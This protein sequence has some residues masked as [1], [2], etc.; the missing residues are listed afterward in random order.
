[1]SSRVITVQESYAQDLAIFRTKFHWGVLFAF[2]LFLLTC[3]LFFSDR[4][5]TIMTM[6]GIAVISVHGLNILT[7][8]CGQ[9]SIGHAGFMAVGGYASAILCAKL[10]FPFWVALPCGALTAGIAGLIFG[11]P[12]LKIKGF[13][14]IMA[15]IA[16]QFI[17]IWTIIQ[18]RSITG[19]ADG[20]SVP[21]PTIGSIALSSKINY[22]Y[23]VM[24]FACLATILAKNIMR[25]RAGRA[26]IAIRDND[27]AAEV[28]GIS[29]W[30]YKLQAFFI[31][32]V[33]AG[34]AGS[35]LIHYYSFA[36]I[37]QFPFMDSVWY[38]GML[39]VG[40][41][42]STTGAVMGA[43]ALRLLDELI[44]MVGP[45]L[46]AAVA[47]QA[48]AS[49]ALISHGLIIIIFLIFEPRGLHH[50]WEMVKAYFR[51]WPFSHEE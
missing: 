42:G 41:M 31:G 30:S 49:L 6:I 23:L 22:F 10:G 35:L 37:D 7:G 28:M 26:F 20:L 11:L 43:V 33:Y 12:S 38:L 27:L 21:K 39:I 46:S 48:A 44:T 17:I 19:G 15:T 5:L 40:G 3:P 14:L 8:Y 47:P 32:C 4:M 51:L 18:L 29:L 9:I 16:A 1:M 34:V 25:T 24:A 50:R 13:Y 36:S 45:I 2:L